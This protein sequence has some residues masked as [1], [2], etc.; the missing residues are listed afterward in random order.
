ML[1]R[2]QEASTRVEINQRSQGVWG[3]ESI[4]KVTVT[5]D[6]LLIF[7]VRCEVFDLLVVLL[8]LFL[9]SHFEFMWPV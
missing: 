6:G 2:L 3:E 5:E 4:P 7:Q 8:G 1:T 9:W